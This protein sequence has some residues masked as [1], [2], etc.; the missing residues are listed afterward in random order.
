V[1]VDNGSSDETSIELAQYPWVEVVSNSVNR[2]FA[3]GCNQ[4]ANVAT[5]EVIVFLNND[6]IVFDGWLDE[7]VSSFEDPSVGAV[8]PRSNNVSGHQWIPDVSYRNE[9]P[10]SIGEFATAWRQ[11]HA[12][13]TS[14]CSRLVGFCLAVRADVFRSVNGFDELYAIGGF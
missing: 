10:A 8:G 1:V 5:G 14:E 2:G 6:T 12:G 11:A 4:G 3:P 13:R 7:L 9:E